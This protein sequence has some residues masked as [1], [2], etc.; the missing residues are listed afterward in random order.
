VNSEVGNKVFFTSEFRVPTS[1]FPI[2]SI[3]STSGEV[4][5]ASLSDRLSAAIIAPKFGGVKFFINKA[6]FIL[7]KPPQK[8][9]ETQSHQ[10]ARRG[11]PKHRP[12]SLRPTSP[13]II[14]PTQTKTPFHNRFFDRP[15]GLYASWDSTTRG[16]HWSSIQSQI[17][18]YR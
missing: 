12:F 4:L 1:H 3:S 13:K 15:M 18:R 6:P 5:T 17:N 10:S 9:A 7:N 11:S 2:V 14:L 16:S 8:T